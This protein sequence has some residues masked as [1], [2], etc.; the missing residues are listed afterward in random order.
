MKT[1][2]Y[3]KIGEIPFDRLDTVPSVEGMVLNKVDSLEGEERQL[4]QSCFPKADLDRVLILSD[5]STPAS[6]AKSLGMTF[7]GGLLIVLGA[8]YFVTRQGQKA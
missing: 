6:L 4:I 5:G 3:K 1:R 8:V 7:G 2:Q